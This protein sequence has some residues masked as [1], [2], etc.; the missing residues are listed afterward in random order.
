MRSLEQR[1]REQAEHCR[2]SG[3]LLMQALL[4]GAADD[5]A[6]GG[7]TRD[8]LGPH[9]G[10]PSGSVPPLRFA[11]ALHRLVLERKAP[12]LALHYPSV[13]GTAPVEQVWPTAERALHEHLEELRELVTRPVQTNEVG[14]SAVLYGGLCCEIQLWV[15]L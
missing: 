14:R 8:L 12:E 13:G 7:I 5:F 9:A 4:T 1:L 3:S 11:G 10:D 2:V 15:V 6:A